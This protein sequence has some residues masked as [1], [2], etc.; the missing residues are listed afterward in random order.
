[1][2]RAVEARQL[3]LFGDTHRLEGVNE[4]PDPVGQDEGIDGG[5][6]Y[7]QNLYAKLASVAL[8]Q[9]G[10]AIDGGAGE[11]ARQDGA[12]PAANAVHAPDIQ[13]VVPVATNAILNGG[14][15]TDRGEHA[16]DDGGPGRHESRRR[17]NRGEA[18]DGARQR[19][20]HA[21]PLLAPPGQRQPGDH[22]RS[23]RGVRIYEH[24]TVEQAPR[25]WQWRST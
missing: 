23:G 5:D 10:G 13:R 17:R 19:A 1:M 8:D 9:P 12:E 22:R 2:Q 4:L 15:A 16:D 21:W 24:G 11:D 20:R 25:Q 7:A 14:V 6:R 18:G 3:D